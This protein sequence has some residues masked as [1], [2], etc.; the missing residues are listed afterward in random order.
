M[1]RALAAAAIVAATAATA[2]AGAGDD[3][4]TAA[5]ARGGVRVALVDQRSLSR[6]TVGAPWSYA[7]DAAVGV[8]GRLT[9]GVS[10]SAPALGRVRGGGGLCRVSSAHECPSLYAGGYLDVRW[11]VP[12]AAAVALIGR[13][14]LDGVTPVKPVVRGGVRV[15]IGRGRWW[16]IAQPEVATAWGHREAGNRDALFAPV[17][18]GVDL[19]PVAAWLETGLRGQ[20]VGFTDKVEVRAGLG[21]AARWRAW[22]VGASA[23]LP[24]ALG[25]QN[26]GAIRHA[27]IWIAFAR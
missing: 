23:G 8:T 15:H 10:H 21:V 4:G 11:R 17:W 22:T 2:H 24:A 14:G 3:V 9:V 1:P 19:G 26:T 7:L 25:P 20:L 13:V 6:R 18:S 27:S 5:L 12:G 16:S